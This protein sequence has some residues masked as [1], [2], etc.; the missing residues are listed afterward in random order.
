MIDFKERKYLS[1]SKNDSEIFSIEITNKTKNIILSSVYRPPDYSLKEFKN[2]LKPIFDNICRNSKDLY[3]V[4]DFNIN[5]LGYENNVKVKNFVNF[6]FQNSLTPLINKPTR[7]TRTNATAIDHILTNAFLNKQIET[8]IIKTEISDHFRIFLITDPITSNE[9]KSK[10]TLPYKRTINTTIT[11][12]LRTFWQEK[13][14]IILRKLIILMK[15]RENFCMISPHFMRK[16][17]QN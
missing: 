16:L 3:L 7:V 5:V 8:G 12:I 15:P 2:P 1:I 9:I 10:R 13:P 14:G 6:A 11:K 17:F 4:G